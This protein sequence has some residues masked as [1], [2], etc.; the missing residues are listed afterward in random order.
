[1]LVRTY[2]VAGVFI[3]SFILDLLM[4]P[5]GP[6]IPL[7]GGILGGMW[8]I[9]AFTAAIA[10]SVLAS[11]SGYW[12]GRRY[13]EY[14]IKK[15]YGQKKYIRWKRFFRRWGRWS[16]LIAA[17][18]PVPYVPLCWT[19]GIFRLGIWRF[20]VYAIIPRALRFIAVMLFAY[21]FLG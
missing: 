7:M 6:D 12:L 3:A 17:L 2:G 9:T 10:G 13:G 14:G 5:I 16:L 8:P 4:Q 1:M 11:L 19:S 20:F 15:I 21:R 18:T